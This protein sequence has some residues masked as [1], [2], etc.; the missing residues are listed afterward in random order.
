MIT[1]RIGYQLQ[2]ADSCKNCRTLFLVLLFNICRSRYMCV[3]LAVQIRSDIY[4]F[5]TIKVTSNAY[6]R[7][8]LSCN[9]EKYI[10][11]H[12]KHKSVVYL[13]NRMSQPTAACWLVVCF[14]A[15][16]VFITLP[17]LSEC[18]DAQTLVKL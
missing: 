15:I 17:L 8:N 14:L 12:V 13:S 2:G 5:H 4:E 6:H 3:N 11:G 10:T 9:L 1:Q 18:C 7:K 16:F